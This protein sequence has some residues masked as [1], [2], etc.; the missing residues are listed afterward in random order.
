VATV[1]AYLIFIRVIERMGWI[2]TQT[3]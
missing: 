3:S 2:A 1:I